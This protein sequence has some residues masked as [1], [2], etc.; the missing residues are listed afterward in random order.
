VEIYLND[1]NIEICY[2]AAIRIKN[3][4]S[5]LYVAWLGKWSTDLFLVD[6]ITAFA[7]AFGLE[8]SDACSFPS[9]QWRLSDF[10]KQEG[11]SASHGEFAKQLLKDG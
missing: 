7:N 2:N 5:E 9:F 10:D 3:K 4:E 11:R 6:D 1:A 8:C